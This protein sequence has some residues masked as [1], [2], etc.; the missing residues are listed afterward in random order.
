[1]G[2][3]KRLSPDIRIDQYDRRAVICRPG[4]APLELRLQDAANLRTIV[5]RYGLQVEGA[6]P[7]GLP[8][9][10]DVA[11]DFLSFVKRMAH[12]CFEE[13]I[14]DD[15]NVWQDAIDLFT[16]EMAKP[17]LPRSASPICVT[18]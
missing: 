16:G 6:R 5:T 15:Y 2:D 7:V 14:D 9:R 10:E 8:V 4:V 17:V 11:Q 3:D 1:M 18:L 13:C 12:Y